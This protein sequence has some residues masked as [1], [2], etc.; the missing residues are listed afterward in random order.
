MGRMIDGEWLEAKDAWASIPSWCGA[1]ERDLREHMG[2]EYA[3]AGDILFCCSG[4]VW[5]KLV[6]AV[7][8]VGDRLIRWVD[9]VS[10][11]VDGRGT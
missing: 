8:P 10:E 7:Y 3:T 11:R 1:L 5:V 6:R 9:R 4:L 2:D